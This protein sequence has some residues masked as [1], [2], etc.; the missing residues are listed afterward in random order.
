MEQP[1]QRLLALRDAL[2]AHFTDRHSRRDKICN[3]LR[4]PPTTEAITDLI[5]TTQ[6]ALATDR[7]TN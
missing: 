7:I 2:V 3:L 4:I 1:Q 6:V 5:A